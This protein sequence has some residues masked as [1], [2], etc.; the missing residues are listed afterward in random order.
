[1]HVRIVAGLTGLAGVLGTAQE[2]ELWM[3]YTEVRGRSIFAGRDYM[4][5]ETVDTGPALVIPGH[6][7][8]A[9]SNYV[10]EHEEEGYEQVLF[11]PEVMVL[12]VK[13]R[14][15]APLTPVHFPSTH[16]LI[17]P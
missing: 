2:C 14:E 3:G 1:M 10:Y 13:T 7:S 17:P 15:R 12:G 11:F 9:L 5:D 6:I 4:Q 16:L 8:D